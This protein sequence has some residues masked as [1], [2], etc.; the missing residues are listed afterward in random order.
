MRKVPTSETKRDYYEILGV[1]RSATRDQLK[2][3]YRHLALKYHPDRSKDPDATAK[4]REIAEAY[5][6]LSDDA[7]NVT[8]T[9]RPVM[10]GSVN[11]GPL[12]ISCAIFSSAISS[13]AGS[14]IVRCV[15]RFFRSTHE[16]S[17]RAEPGRGFA[18]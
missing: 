2:Q 16:T 1:D 11:V 7:R 14:V 5:A 6:V 17:L 3:A 10:L 4:F 18:V 8:S 12:K 9:M 15:W 13:G